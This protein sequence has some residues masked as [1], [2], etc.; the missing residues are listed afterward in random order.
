MRLPYKLKACCALKGLCVMN[1]CLY[2]KSV[3]ICYSEAGMGEIPETGGAH[4]AVQ[5]Q[6]GH[7][8]GFA[9]SSA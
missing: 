2:C 4:Q 3:L 5:Q 6:V 7:G 1:M 8:S 9:I